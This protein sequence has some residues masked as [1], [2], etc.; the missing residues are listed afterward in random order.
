MKIFLTLISFL[1]L[2]NLNMVHQDRILKIDKDGK[3]IGLPKNFMPAQ[4]DLNNNRLRIHDKEITL[5]KC[6]SIYFKE[7]KNPKLVLTASWY[8]S[9]TTLPYYLNFEISGKD[10]NGY[11]ILIDLETLN[12]IYIHKISSKEN[13]ILNSEVHVSKE[14]LAE[15]KKAIRTVN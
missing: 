1:F 3:I 8:H 7:Y 6:V 10:A 5:P 11:N 9:K 15:Y 13:T 14:C 2:T 4:F 12:L